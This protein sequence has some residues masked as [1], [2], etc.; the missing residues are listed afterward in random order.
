M[1]DIS[2]ARTEETDYSYYAVAG[3]EEQQPPIFIPE[4]ERKRENL[5][6]A[7]GTSSIWD[8]RFIGYQSSSEADTTTHPWQEEIYPKIEMLFRQAREESF[9]DGME[10]K[11][12]RS[13]KL[14]ILTYGNHVMNVITRLII[15]ER[16]N[17]EVASEALRWIG[18]IHH[19]DTYTKRLWLLQK[20]LFCSSPRVR[21]GAA[22]G[23]AYLDDPA[24]RPRLSSAIEREQ[25]PELKEDMI[26]VLKR[27]GV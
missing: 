12:S 15:N 8:I 5:G 9:E 2:L 14:Y 21:D 6:L 19:P 4:K 24:A 13:L 27:L 20:A 23:I 10:S 1:S 11:F 3:T 26:Q 25:I 16:V 17:A 18:L 7:T 22:L